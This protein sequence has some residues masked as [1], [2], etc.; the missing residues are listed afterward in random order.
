MKKIAVIGN[1]TTNFG[2][3]LDMVQA[4][5]SELEMELETEAISVELENLK[6]WLET[7]FRIEFTGAV[8]CEPH[9]E[10]IGLLV[11][12]FSQSATKVGA[13]NTLINK[14]GR[15]IAANTEAVAVLKSIL[16][17]V[18]PNKKNVVV[19]GDNALARATVFACQSA[20][21]NVFL[22]SDDE[23]KSK[24]LIEKFSIQPWSDRLDIDESTIVVRTNNIKTEALGL[25]NLQLA[26]E[27]ANDNFETSL[28]LLAD[29]AG[30]SV[31]SKDVFMAKSL[32]EQFQLWFE[33]YPE[34]EI[35]ESAYLG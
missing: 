11:D 7:D 17:A 5:L 13:V 10:T 4:G 25:V 23:R 28:T 8:I 32:Q 9:K 29:E 12:E 35:F 30:S 27:L 20:G 15:I 22:A 34:V 14:N 6:D 24:A 18:D 3:W 21:S 19:V 16:T 31:V 33:K 1:E 2:P 26:V